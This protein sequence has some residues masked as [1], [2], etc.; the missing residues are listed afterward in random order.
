MT[1]SNCNSISK[2]IAMTNDECTSISKTIA[3]TNDDCNSISKTTAMTNNDC[4]ST[5]KINPSGYALILIKRVQ[6]KMLKTYVGS[7]VHEH[8]ICVRHILVEAVNPG[9]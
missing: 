3:M 2:T 5:S 1:N 7:V 8:S 6:E 4:N 9:T